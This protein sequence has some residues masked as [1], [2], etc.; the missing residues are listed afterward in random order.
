M[1]NNLTVKAKLTLGNLLVLVFLLGFSGYFYIN[2]TQTTQST[3][4]LK[5]YIKDQ[6]EN[7]S[8]L[9]MVNN[10]TIRDQ[11]QKNY[12]LNSDAKLKGSLAKRVNEFD[13]LI[14]GAKLNASD[15]QQRIL[16]ELVVDNEKLNQL[17]TKK[18]FP[19]VDQK[20][21]AADK[22]NNEFG[23]NLEKMSADLTEYAIKDSDSVLVSISSR[24]TQKLL[25][26]RAYFNL[27][28]STDSHT[29]L[30][31]SE[32]EV[33]GIYYQLTEMK[34]IA[35]R[36][37]WVPVKKL[38][39]FTIL[40]EQQYQSIVQIKQ[41][42]AATNLDISM[43]TN[44]INEKMLNQILGQWKV[45]DSDAGQTLE[46]VYELRTNGL[47]VILAIIIGNFVIIWFIGNNITKGLKEL[48]L[49][50]A[51]INDGDGD[52]TKRVELNSRDEIGQ[53]ATSFNQFIEQIQNLVASS[54][55]SLK[56][57]DEFST[58][59]VSM[60]N[61]SKIA[62]E[63]QLEET[64][65][66]SVSIEE[67]SA[68]A[69]DISKDTNSSASIVDMTNKSVS[70][71]QK[72]SHSSVSSV[73][74]LHADI[75]NTHSVI[76]KLATEAL[77][78]GGV[79]EVIKGM[80]EQTNLLALNAAIEAARAGD[81]GR[82]FAVVADEVRSLASRTKVSVLEIEEIIQRLQKQ[83]SNAVE[84]IDKSLS[85]AEVNKG[86][87][88]DTQDSFG[89]I[90]Q[91][92]QELN[93]MISSVASACSEQSQVTNQV[94]E[95]VSTVYSLSQQGAELTDKSAQVIV[96]SANS[97]AELNEIMNKFKV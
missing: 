97:V 90:E 42:I 47:L 16:E 14:E 96:Q 13:Q 10:I 82:G 93:T 1:L 38:R 71:G 52:L 43:Q 75:T 77:A 20:N 64:N 37:K 92:I 76:A 15:Q 86:H 28:M 31:R 87:V 58:T 6:A 44:A 95:K 5:T 27:Y 29:L 30:E 48:L 79:V 19:L 45:L 3:A 91:S 63:Q 72:S 67:L 50:L 32:L 68:S 62:L 88:L 60:A 22:I 51:D 39:E 84:L 2:L 34:K 4:A 17:I 33:S 54:Q 21:A 69:E 83:T 9:K 73:E 46:R 56:E 61:E 23:P 66:I 57:V 81:A 59:N 36:K 25:A 74:S 7:G 40:L 89:E 12:Q 70:S 35:S 8:S 53:L 26:S 78:I 55:R 11:I 85:S 49:R 65:S 80:S 94:S 41:E 24:M 18:L